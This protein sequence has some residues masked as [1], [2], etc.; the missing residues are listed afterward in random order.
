MSIPEGETEKHRKNDLD[1]IKDIL[2]IPKIFLGFPKSFIGSW[3]YRVEMS[4]GP[5]PEIACA[6]N[7]PC[8]G[9]SYLLY[10]QNMTTRT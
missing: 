8:V 7:A 6:L 4:L 2:R 3:G 5:L 1:K 10:N 9:F